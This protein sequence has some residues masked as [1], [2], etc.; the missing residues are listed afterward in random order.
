MISPEL[1]A[2][3]LRLHGA[4]KWK[5]GTI[6]TQVGV[7]HSTVRRALSQAG[8]PAG[9]APVRPS[10]VD[11]FVPLIKDTLARYPALRASRLYEMAK[12]RGYPGGPDHFRSVV[13]RFRPRP[14]AEAYLRLRTLPGEQAQV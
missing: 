9:Q 7:H 5:I 2:K 1:E 8:Q 11:P 13:A 3:I 4:E 12:E 14:H 10:F 6:A